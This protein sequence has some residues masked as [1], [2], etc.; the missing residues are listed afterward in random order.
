MPYCWKCGEPLPDAAAPCPACGATAND[1]RPLPDNASDEAKAL[2]AIYDRYGCQKVLTQPTILYNALGDF[3][4]EDGRKLRSQIRLAMDAG[5]GRLYL[6][7]L[8][9]PTPTRGSAAR[10]LITDLDF[11]ADTARLITS[12]FDD[13]T[14]LP[15]AEVAQA[16]APAKPTVPAR[17]VPPVKAE[18]AAPVV[19]IPPSQWG[20][21]R[22]NHDS[23]NQFVFGSQHLRESIRTITFR[24]KLFGRP[25]SA[26]DVSK[27][28][29]GTI[30]AWVQPTAVKD[31]HNSALY[32]LIIAGKG[33]VR[34]PEDSSNLFHSFKNVV[35]IDFSQC[36]D[37]SGVKN[38]SYMFYSC[39]ALTSL[40]LS[41]FNTSRVTD[42]SSMFACCY[43]LTTLNLSS[44]NTASVATMVAMFNWCQALT[45]L[46]LSS[47]DTYRVYDMSFMFSHCESMTSLNLSSFD[48]SRANSLACMFDGCSSLASL[49]LSSF[50]T[51]RVFSMSYMF[52]GCPSLTAVTASHAFVIPDDA[53]T[54]DMFTDCPL[55]SISDFTFVD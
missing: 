39:N 53:D 22:P 18:P 48:T 33:G 5:L 34:L 25:S 31:S 9:A 16:P 4:G 3:L 30:W 24:D 27:A 42:M 2:R 52:D 28:K 49:N 15:W 55:N 8:A 23:D 40:N 37:S 32:D 36:V 46:N 51:S 47:F 13:M 6:A 41:S 11:T 10:N 43:A 17:P 14:G 19:S 44:F 26:W 29:D 54:A 20:E 7:E 50:D 38:M 35:R 21:L 1:R 45:S 12:L